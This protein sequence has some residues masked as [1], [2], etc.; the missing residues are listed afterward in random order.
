MRSMR[1][2]R[3]L[4]EKKERA[5][6]MAAFSVYL[7]FFFFSPRGFD[8]GHIF[9]PFAKSLIIS[10]EINNKSELIHN[11][12]RVRIYCF[13]AGGRTRTGTMSPS[14]DFESTTST[15]SITPAGARI[16]YYIFWKIASTFLYFLLF[17]HTIFAIAAASTAVRAADA[18]SACLFGFIDI[19]CCTA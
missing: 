5:A 12:E 11:R 16:V 15:N 1:A 2:K 19:K 6:D 4:Q 17:Q 10:C 3:G 9:Q 18:F 13:G 14:V 7:C 8:S